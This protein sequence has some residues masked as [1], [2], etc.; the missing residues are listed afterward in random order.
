[1]SDD[2]R[3]S[4]QSASP[5]LDTALE[6]PAAERAAWLA[7]IRAEAPGLADQIARW[8]SECEAV[9]SGGFLEG[10][11]VIEPARTALTGLQLGA[12]RLV[13]PLGHGGMGSV[14]LAERTDGRFDDRVAVKLLN[15]ALVGRTGEDRFAREGRILGKLTHPQIARIIDAGVSPVGQPYLVLEHVEGEPIDAHC[16]RRRLGPAER[17]RLFLDVLTPVAHAHANLVVHRD[18]KP[19]NVMVTP[20]GQVKL[21]D[22]G[23]AR[24]LEAEDGHPIGPQLTR[25][26]DALLTPAYAAPEQVTNGEISTATDVYA[27]GV[28][29]YVLLS[30]RHPAGAVLDSPAGLLHA[31]VDTDPPPMS[32]RAVEADARLSATPAAI[33]EARG[34][35]PER[36]RRALCGDLDT[37]VLT[38]M[39]K[40]P[41]ARYPTVTAFAD[42]LRRS[43]AHEP[44]QAQRDA[45]R[46]RMAKFVRRNRVAAALAAVATLAVVI[47]ASATW[48][49]SRRAAAERDFA[50]RQLARAESVNDMNAFLLSD[51]APLG[52]AFTAGDLLNR[53]E[54][55]I[56]R[57][58]VDPPDET[59]VEALI[60]IGRHY[61]AQDED[62]NAR[63]TLTR[64]YDLSRALPAASASTRAKAACALAGALARG[65][66]VTRAR[67]LVRDGLADVPPGRP[68]LLD[69]VFCELRA[70]EVAREVG[71]AGADVAHAQTA[72]RM[73]RASGLGS[74]LAAL[75]V[76]I[77][78]A[79]SLRAAG[80]N[81]EASAAF[82]SALARLEAMGRDRTEMAGTLLNNWG[83]SRYLLGQPRDAERLFRRAVEIGSADQAGASVSPMLLNNLAR[84]ILEQGRSAEAL[85]IAE[86]A[87]AEAARL[88]NGVALLQSMLLRAT[89]HR[90]RGDLVEAGALLA[91]FERQQRERLPPDHVA[92]SALASEQALL[93]EARGDLAGAARFAD[94]AVAISEASS[95]GRELL[96]RGLVRRAN[97]SLI[98]GRL[99]AALADAERGLALELA[100]AEA[101]ALSSVLGRAHLTMGRVF[102]AAD[103][104]GDARTVLTEAVRHL[105]YAV[106]DDHAD[107]RHARDLLSSLE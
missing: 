98:A 97:L 1:M 42:D 13:E 95:Q 17:V 94:R 45:F 31:I 16:D 53:A 86:R 14:W 69:R 11:A 80:R 38:A 44:I 25:S 105:A 52:R 2:H 3:A 72:E 81:T 74:E 50:L 15:A 28:L 47:G 9:E 59:T 106:G 89:A 90:E 40:A 24:L 99:D 48:L 4:W 67:E 39:A 30:G 23:I 21:L 51:A 73:L 37:I 79:E 54:Q 91:E 32:Q 35:S 96:A 61:W 82:A 71:D 107:T 8:L 46:V 55:L 7:A 56:N 104:D 22:F 64:A 92:F 27:L 12:Y 63:R 102:H 60:S 18:L 78:L 76:A 58:P 36:L 70:S 103:R 29:L 57:H 6:L 34:T 87:A 26:G 66:A 77:H 83:L 65:D 101:G 84:P 20:A 68:F 41:A 75:N 49:Q 43:L 62:D 88:G 19:S 33:A 10:A 85:A 5:F 100:R 93:D